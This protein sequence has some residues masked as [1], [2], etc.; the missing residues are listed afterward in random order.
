MEPISS[1]ISISG[2][3]AVYPYPVIDLQF[4]S[5]T[6]NLSLEGY[7]EALATIYPAKILTGRFKMTFSGIVDTYYSDVLVNDTA[8]PT[9]LRTVGFQNNSLNVGYTSGS[10]STRR[11]GILPPVA[12]GFVLS[13]VVSWF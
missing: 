3:R 8:T 5:K 10:S 9:W 11:T 1:N 4:D 7:F 6:A 12:I 2:S 13:L